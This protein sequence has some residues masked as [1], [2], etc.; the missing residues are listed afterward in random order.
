MISTRQGIILS[1]VSSYVMTICWSIIGLVKLFD[2]D[3]FGFLDLLVG[4]SEI[5]RLIL[6][7]KKYRAISNETFE[8]E[9][10]RVDEMLV[11]S[12]LLGIY[13]NMALCYIVQAVSSHVLILIVFLF[14]LFSVMEMFSIYQRYNKN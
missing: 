2:Q 3:W 8:K 9:N 7:H 14:V 13:L 5:V 10:F 6:N 12:L 1:L 4:G 11:S